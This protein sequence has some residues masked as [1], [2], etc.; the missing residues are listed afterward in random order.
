MIHKLPKPFRE[1]GQ[2]IGP[3]GYTK[4]IC[5]YYT[6]EQMLQF[7]CDAMEEAAQLC[8]SLAVTACNDSNITRHECADA[9]CVL[10]GKM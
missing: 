1:Q 5:D 9:I 8:R 2:Q 7:R 3:D 6:A 10:A 4:A